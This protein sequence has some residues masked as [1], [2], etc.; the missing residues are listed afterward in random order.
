MSRSFQRQAAVLAF[1]AL[2]SALALY[3]P[4]LHS[5]THVPGAFVTDYFHFHWSYWWIRHALTTPGLSVYETDFVMFPYTTNLA[6]Y[7]LAP[8]WFPLWAALDPLIG[9]LAAVNVIFW[10]AFTL[11]GYLFYL[12][13]RRENAPAEL[14]LVGGVLLAVNPI[15]LNPV[16]W[17]NTNL[18]GA[19]WFPLLILIWG[20][21]ARDVAHVGLYPNV[22]PRPA[23]PGQ[24]LRERGFFPSLFMGKGRGWGWA[25]IMGVALYAMVMMD[26]QYPLFA[27]WLLLPYVLLTLVR[28]GSWAARARL[29]AFGVLALGLALALLWFAGP[30]PYVLK[31][32]RA[33]LAPTPLEG[34]ES[35]PFP[36]G[37][38]RRLDDYWFTYSMG[39][40][41]TV[42]TLASLAAHLIPSVRAQGRADRRRWF[43]LALAVLPFLFTL[44]PDLT[45]G[46]LT[47]PMPY[48]L[49]HAVFG[50]MFRFPA[51]FG[52]VYAVP[53]LLFAGRTWG[54]LLR[55]MR[56]QAARP[57]VGA[58]LLLFAALDQRLFQPMPVQLP[59]QPYTFYAQIGAEQGE[60]YDR[61]VV[62]EIPTA[63][64]TG[65]AGVGEFE[66]MAFQFYGITHG[67]RMIN[68]HFSRA[69]V[70]HF[71]YLRTDD[72]MLS[73]FGQRRLLEP[74]AV[75]QQLEERIYAWPIG[76]IVVHQ[77]AIG[78]EGPTA[79]EIIGYLNQLDDLLCPVVVERDAVFYRTAWHPDGCPPRTPPEVSPGVYQID[80][81]A[82][83]DERYL[84]WGWHGLERV[85][86]LTLR[87]TG[88]YPQADLYVDLPPGGYTVTLAAQSFWRDRALRLRVNG[89]SVGRATVR[90][91]A[92]AEYRFTVPAAQ[93]G[94]GRH[95]TFTLVYQGW[96]VAADLGLSADARRLALAVD[97]MR[98][99]QVE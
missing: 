53:A 36:D 65:E 52:V 12:L 35:I 13:L 26:L 74:D 73:W 4:L 16:W 97:W 96:D 92:L 77:D 30:L 11:S 60:P 27:V 45:V 20:R 7:T 42:I 44:G 58:V 51:R 68:G 23:A 70:D 99:A 83:G 66:D 41:V 63:A 48:R 67:K 86:D 29:I 87:W 62:V 81:G 98:F 8:F 79:Q 61:E 33:L 89:V 9:T 90:E 56:P 49:L 22:S 46:S 34:T 14:A 59:P 85:F 40:S 95:V 64:G 5:G 17:S 38:L 80:I 15:M 50:G 91:G 1:F 55:R 3:Y 94:D 82:E 71:W 31:Y 32:D 19:F 84:G 21:V 75:R 47:L 88:E 76:Y 54:P 93:I 37:Y 10:A 6:F 57:W 28:A 24:T 78:R 18:L 72:P 43:W 69:P 2:V 39:A 25:L